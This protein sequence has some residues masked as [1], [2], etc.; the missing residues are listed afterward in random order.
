MV[1]EKGFS[2][3][4]DVNDS[5]E[6]YKLNYLHGLYKKTPSQLPTEKEISTELALLYIKHRHPETMAF[7][8]SMSNYDT[9]IVLKAAQNSGMYHVAA[10]LFRKAGGY[11]EGMQVI[12]ENIKSFT[13]QE[14]INYAMEIDQKEVWNKFKEQAFKNEDLLKVMLDN[15]PSLNRKTIDYIDFMRKIPPEMAKKIDFNAISEKTVKEFQRRLATATLTENIVATGAFDVYQK[16]LSL[17]KRAK[18]IIVQ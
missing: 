2:N 6:E 16:T 11:G 12:L 5:D 4:A 10:Y 8:N 14:A 13:A 9:R 15:L 7:L 18:K 1:L 17:K 3:I